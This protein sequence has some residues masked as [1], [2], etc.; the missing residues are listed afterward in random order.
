MEPSSEDSLKNHDITTTNETSKYSTYNND[1]AI[2]LR[3]SYSKLHRHRNNEKH[4]KENSRN[5][6]PDAFHTIKFSKISHS[7]TPTLSTLDRPRKKD[8][9]I[10]FSSDKKRYGLD[11]FQH[12]G[13]A[14][15]RA[16]R[17][18]ISPNFS[19]YQWSADSIY[20]SNFH[21]KPPGFSHPPRALSE[22]TNFRGQR[23]HFMPYMNP[24]FGAPPYTGYPDDQN[25]LLRHY[26]A[27]H[28]QRRNSQSTP[29][30]ANEKGPLRSRHFSDTLA[31]TQY[32]Y[33]LQHEQLSDNHLPPHYLQQIQYLSQL[34]QTCFN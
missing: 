24:S 8:D 17:N 7:P 4:K 2:N 1:A 30:I 26:T 32:P 27:S 25:Y 9:S 28:F 6:V 31:S 5:D 14:S 21:N 20:P 12:E 15:R 3:S 23:Q 19:N 16:F 11:D 33:P 34:Q 29:S 18:T 13:R 10:N 22:F